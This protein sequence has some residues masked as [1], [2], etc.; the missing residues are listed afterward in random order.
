MART[1]LGKHSYRTGFNMLLCKCVGWGGG[2]GAGC[3][4]LFT[5][6]S[7]VI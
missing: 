7:Q 5:C 2:G 3:G 1:F 4:E 6:G